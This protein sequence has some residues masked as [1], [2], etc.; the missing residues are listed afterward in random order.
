MPFHHLLWLG[1][2]GGIV[3]CPDAIAVLAFAIYLRQIVWGLVVIVAFSFGLA[4]VLIAIGIV[5]VK[6]RGALEKR[7][8]ERRN[9]FLRMAPAV[10]AVFVI[11]VGGWLTWAY[12][13]ALGWI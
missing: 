8:D 4:A 9:R 10:S 12:V 3:P 11:A 13:K 5:F 2:T 1:I 6:A 7:F